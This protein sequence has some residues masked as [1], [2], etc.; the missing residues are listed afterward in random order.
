MKVIH[1]LRMDLARCGCR[2]VVAAVQGEANTRVLAVSLYDNGV[3]WEPAEGVT[4]AVAFKKPDGACG[5]YDKLPNGDEATTIT[6]SEVTAILAPQALTVPGDVMA[7]IVFFDQALNR[8]ATFPFRIRVEVDPAGGQYISDNYYKYST[9]EEVN[10][11][12]EAALASMEAA[13]QELLSVSTS[14]VLCDLSGETITAADSSDRPLSGLTVYGKTTQNGTPSPES[15]V[16]LE[17]VGDSGSVVVSATGKNIFGGDVLAD[18]FVSEAK[19]TKDEANRTITYTPANVN[20]KVLFRFRN[21]NPNARYTIILFGSSSVDGA[22]QT[23]IGINYTDGTSTTINFKAGS[24][25]AIFTTASGKTPKTMYGAWLRGNITLYYDKCGIFEGVLSEADFEPYIPAQTL[26]IQTPNGLPGINEIVRDCKDYGSGTHTQMVG[27]IDSYAGEEITGAYIS[28]TGEL[29]NGATV[30]Y[31]LPEP[32]ETPIPAEEM[33][34]YA[35]LH[36]N[37]PNTTIFNDAGAY[38]E[39][40]YVADTKLYIDNKFTELQNAILAT[41]ANI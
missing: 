15:P 12:V 19:A 3:A 7:S 9:M 38:M 13:K 40:E 31:E 21:L 14:G 30:L 27:K 1:N 23:N 11:V 26:T 16:P 4:A 37:K 25:Y 20:T 29:S 28:S 41:G 39:V 8:L 10:A 6:G 24:N 18:K 34:Q 5:L 17:S 36:T 35:A 22:T 33:A 32:I 2:P